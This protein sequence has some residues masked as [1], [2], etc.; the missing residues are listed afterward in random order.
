VTA[1]ALT[2][3]AAP[4]PP[5]AL[6]VHVPFC[7]SICPYCDFVVVAGAAARGPRSSVGRYLD[8]LTAEL[9]LRAGALDE[10]FGRPSTSGRPD[11]AS[12]YLGGGTPSLLPAASIAA[13]VDLVRDRFGL[14]E[15]AEVTLEA[16]PG[17]DER[18]A[19]AAIRAAGVTRL[20]F[21]AL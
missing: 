9:E 8:A 13:I 20:S 15:Q 12:L 11:L 16:N 19:A 7:V 1:P 10:R 17:S 6:Y 3:T 4:R 14:A 21:G 5:V 18:G 2:V